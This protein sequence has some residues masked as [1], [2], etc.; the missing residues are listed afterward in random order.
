MFLFLFIGFL[1]L[2]LFL[3]RATAPAIA[4]LAAAVVI[5]AFMRCNE[6]VQVKPRPRGGL[7]F[8][9]AAAHHLRGGVAGLAL[10]VLLLIVLR[11]QRRFCVATPRA[12]HQ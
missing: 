3:R 9:T 12:P 10:A 8:I 4:R 11:R 1:L 7:L 6:C 5:L 2:A